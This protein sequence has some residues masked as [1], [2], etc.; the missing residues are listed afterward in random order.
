M[1]NKDYILRGPAIAVTMGGYE[2]PVF[3]DLHTAIN[4]GNKPPGVSI[5]GAPGRGKTNLAL[6]L[7]AMSAVVGKQ[8]IYLDPKADAM[9]M[10]GLADEL[11]KINSWDLMDSED[12]ILD[13]FVLEDDKN[14]QIEKAFS[15]I[16]MF[17]RSI[18][19]K[20]Y[21]KLRAIITDV[22]HGKDPSLTK[23]MSVLQSYDDDD[24]AVLGTELDSLRRMPFSRL[25]FKRRGQ[26]VKKHAIGEGLTI[27]TIMGLPLPDA[28]TRKEDYRSDNRLAIGIMYLITDFLSKAMQE[29]RYD[30]GLPKSIIIDEA[31]AVM[32]NQ[33]GLATIANI[34]RLGRSMNTACVLIT[35]NMK[36]FEG[37]KLE[38]SIST[39]FVFGVETPEEAEDT[40]VALQIPPAEYAQT[41]LGLGVGNCLMQDYSKRVAMVHI[42][43]ENKRWA[44]AFETNPMKKAA[45]KR[46]KAQE[47]LR[48]KK[49]ER[50]NAGLSFDKKLE[51][52]KSLGFDKPMDASP[53]QLSMSK[54]MDMRKY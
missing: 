17:V 41:V 29:S 31:W 2:T 28:R 16:E 54:G 21:S 18:N 14:Q 47:L 1:G 48:R 44:E 46:A 36:D 52:E 13:P 7:A 26:T 45:N 24:I 34:L 20:Q 42:L 40:C 53:S 25:C 19:N 32:S 4:M 8:T 12:G 37:T 22:A 51:F 30:D 39:H 43:R 6:T 49:A 11:G 35:Q 10:M 38:N 33:M 9:G 5:T 27:I 15:L 23:V 3:Y 50:E